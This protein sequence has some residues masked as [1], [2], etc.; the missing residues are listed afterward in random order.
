M[1]LTN[2]LRRLKRYSADDESVQL[3]LDDAE[4]EP[5]QVWPVLSRRVA[6]LLRAVGSGHPSPRGGSDDAR[7]HY[8]QLPPLQD[9]STDALSGRKLFFKVRHTIEKPL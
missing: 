7:G 8:D 2:Q 4:R 9:V 1:T 6:A 3:A 5:L